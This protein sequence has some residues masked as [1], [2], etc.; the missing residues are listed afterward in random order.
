MTRQNHVSELIHALK[1]AHRTVDERKKSFEHL[2]R[3]RGSSTENEPASSS[4]PAN[5]TTIPDNSSKSEREGGSRGNTRAAAAAA[6][7]TGPTVTVGAVP[8]HGG[9]E[10]GMVALADD[11][12]TPRWNA[13]LKDGQDWPPYDT[14]FKNPPRSYAIACGIG[15][16]TSLIASIASVVL[17]NRLASCPTSTRRA[18]FVRIVALVPVLAVTASLSTAFA[19]VAVGFE[20][21]RHC[22][23]GLVV[24]WLLELGF[25]LLG[26]FEAA[27]GSLALSRPTSVAILEAGSPDEPHM[28]SSS[29]ASS[30][31]SGLRGSPRAV[32]ASRKLLVWVWRLS[33]QYVYVNSLLAALLAAL[34]LVSL[35]QHIPPLVDEAVVLAVQCIQLC[36][37][38]VASASLLVFF[39]SIKPVL[40]ILKYRGMGKAGLVSAAIL[41]N[42]VQAPILR[43]M[44]M[45]GLLPDTPMFATDARATMWNN[46]LLS[47]EAPVFAI[48]AWFCFP[49]KKR[50]LGFRV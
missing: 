10:I 32:H 33:T 17:I 25:D 21:L 38:L 13:T 18:L 27:C 8:G 26:G 30:S 24:F 3:K 16:G 19:S 41:M 15:A 7:T 31:S 9:N 44:C 37:A 43:G 39:T 2:R 35:V 6:A 46:W 14:V 48:V 12:L 50:G 20:L 4:D 49:V 45:S 1:I 40:L 22:Y 34:S 5:R 42:A 28:S 47:V 11:V 23:F 29:F 36:S